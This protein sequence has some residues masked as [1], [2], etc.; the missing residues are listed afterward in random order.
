M[1]VFQ[2]KSSKSYVLPRTKLFSKKVLRYSQN[3]LNIKLNFFYKITVWKIKLRLHK[4]YRL[5]QWG[6]DDVKSKIIITLNDFNH[7]IYIACQNIT[8]TFLLRPVVRQRAGRN[9]IFFSHFIEKLPIASHRLVF[10]FQLEFLTSNKTQFTN[11][12][13]ILYNYEK[14]FLQ[15]NVWNSN[16][17]FIILF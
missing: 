14:T 2:V 6:H 13:Y 1:N 10:V 3:L 7:K 11:C 15:L 8:V 5:P 9:I 16:K 17:F 4:Y 12:T